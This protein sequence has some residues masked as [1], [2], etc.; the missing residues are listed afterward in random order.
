ML[1][2]AAA[3][4]RQDLL[5]VQQHTT[6][7]WVARRAT[8][9]PSCGPCRSAGAV[10]HPDRGHRAAAECRNRSAGTAMPNALMWTAGV[11][12]DHPLVELGLGMRQVHE[13]AV[14]AELGAQRPVETLDLPG[15]RRRAG[16]GQQ[17]LDPVLA[18]DPV[19]QHL[20]RRH[21]EPTGEHLAVVGQDLPRQ[22]IGPQRRRQSRHRP[23][24]TTRAP[25]DG[26]LDTEPEVD[27][28][29]RSTPWPDARRPAR[30]HRPRPSATAPSAAHAPTASTSDPAVAAPRDR[31]GSTG[32]A[33]GTPPTPTA[34]APP[35]PWPA[36]RPTAADPTPDAHAALRNRH[37]HS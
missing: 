11:V 26:A 16:L 14:G 10:D 7:T 24:G 25:S 34:P 6:P 28:R 31:S 35:Q 20:D 22:P 8:Q 32:P 12:V 17:M 4:P 33:P 36:R 18:A 1:W 5:P 13:H 9:S 23:A 3:T 2:P 29:P 15:G 19:E 37:L 30:T 27:H 21:V